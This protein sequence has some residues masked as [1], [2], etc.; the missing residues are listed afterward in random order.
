[1]VQHSDQVQNPKPLS[2]CSSPPTAAPLT[3][4]A[5]STLLSSPSP[6]FFYLVLEHSKQLLPPQASLLTA[7]L[8]GAPTPLQPRTG[9]TDGNPGWQ[10]AC[11]HLNAT[12]PGRN[13]KSNLSSEL[14]L[15]SLAPATS[16]LLHTFCNH[17]SYNLVTSHY[18]PG[19]SFPV[20]T[21]V[22]FLSTL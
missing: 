3:P 6:A 11:P 9:V 20:G 2:C 17:S 5:S 7:L 14:L 18:V 15:F 4:S 19:A 10:A 8:S 13:L 12:G 21:T 16:A 1:M 22:A